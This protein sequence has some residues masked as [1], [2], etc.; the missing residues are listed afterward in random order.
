MKTKTFGRWTV[1]RVACSGGVCM[2]LRSGAR[3]ARRDF[4]E[5]R[6]NGTKELGD[7][8]GDGRHTW[9]KGEER[10][11]GYVYGAKRA[12]G[13]YDYEVRYNPGPKDLEY[14]A[15]HDKIYLTRLLHEGK[16][17]KEEP[18]VFYLWETD[19]VLEKFVGSD[20]GEWWYHRYCNKPDVDE[21]LEGAEKAYKQLMAQ[22]IA[23]REEEARRQQ[24]AAERARAE[25]AER[26]RLLKQEQKSKKR[27]VKKKQKEYT[28]IP[29]VKNEKD[30][31]NS[32]KDKEKV[33]ENDE[34]NIELNQRVTSGSGI[35]EK[36]NPLFKALDYYITDL[37]LVKQAFTRQSAIE[38]HHPDAAPKSYQTLETLGDAVLR[39]SIIHLLLTEKKEI[40]WI[41]AG[42]HNVSVLCVANK[43]I[44]LLVSQRLHL[45][46]YLIKGNGEQI[47]DK[48]Y[49]DA[50]EALLGAIH[51][52]AFPDE[53][54]LQVIKKLW[55][56]YI[57]NIILQ[58][59]N[60]IDIKL[61]DID[62]IMRY[63][64]ESIGL[65]E[66]RSIGLAAGSSTRNI[67]ISLT[68]EET[69][70][71]LLSRFCAIISPATTF[72]SS[73]SASSTKA[74]VN[75]DKKPVT[76]V[77]ALPRS[78]SPDSSSKGIYQGSQ[79]KACTQTFFPP[80]AQ[81]VASSSKKPVDPS[82]P[83]YKTRLCKFFEKHGTCHRGNH[84][85]FAHGET[86][87]ISYGKNPRL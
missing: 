50:M 15:L 68:D 71:E 75:T 41:P 59:K 65:P 49:A 24:A 66:S 35:A 47:N 46:R 40:E 83:L 38:E 14:M 58:D 7:V 81:N 30:D 17:A 54:E 12:D 45:E 70:E 33:Y 8:P 76:E 74:S 87:L 61:P 43:G 28:A 84:C 1:R 4:E 5:K 22:F 18:K 27:E 77:K 11:G 57:D 63:E 64:S 32:A 29:V 13:Y 31:K 78:K 42:L 10:S 16:L 72:S 85:N 55:G 82:N 9:I 62:N 6:R 19:R 44:P 86:E 48:M 80:Q 26:Q 52:D 51:L 73:S 56:P 20:I 69:E 60:T 34:K 67:S 2:F 39:L 79:G 23:Q 21:K 3:S 25:E 37:M 53:V 36:Y